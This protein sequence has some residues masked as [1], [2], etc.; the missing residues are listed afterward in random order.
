M[1]TN[2]ES[3]TQEVL[4]VNELVITT[5]TTTTSDDKL[6]QPGLTNAFRSPFITDEDMSSIGMM[7]LILIGERHSK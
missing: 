5:Q 2:Q 3:A 4:A 1:L 7:L 6:C